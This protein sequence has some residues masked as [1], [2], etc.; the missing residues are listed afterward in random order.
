MS[1]AS[2]EIISLVIM[3]FTILGHIIIII[4]IL[5][6]HFQSTPKGTIFF[7]ATSHSSHF[8]SQIVFFFSNF[9]V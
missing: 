3:T 8:L 7:G 9:A 1:T 6:S 4:Y 2:V 5:S